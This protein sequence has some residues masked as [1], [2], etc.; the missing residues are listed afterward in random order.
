[1][2]A[3]LF[4][5][6]KGWKQVNQLYE[7]TKQDIKKEDSLE[8]SLTEAA[9]A[10]D[11]PSGY[12]IDLGWYGNFGKKRLV[13]IIVKDQDWNNPIEEKKLNTFEDTVKWVNKWIKKIEKIEDSNDLDCEP[14]FD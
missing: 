4:N 12:M 9:L 13:G 6:K 2:K 14:T 10:I 3:H 8:Y 7:F 5:V 1:M 11:S